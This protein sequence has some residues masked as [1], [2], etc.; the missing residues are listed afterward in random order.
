VR[1]PSPPSRSDLHPEELGAYD[2]MLQRQSD[3]GLDQQVPYF[4][5]LLNSPLTCHYINELGVV[6]R[7]HGTRGD[8]YA[9]KDRAWVDLVLGRQMEK[10]TFYAFILPAAAY[11]VR[12]A[13]IEAVW[14]ERDGNLTPEELELTVYIRQ[15]VSQTVTDASYAAIEERLG[16]R[17]AVELTAFIGHLLMTLTLMKAFDSIN[18][19]ATDEQ[20]EESIRT[21]LDGTADATEP[22]LPPIRPPIDH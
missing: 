21:V 4:S 9:Q 1:P 22:I 19:V 6:Y 20:I 5:A 16:A 10:G 2:R 14:R 3:Y 13:A 7:W 12:P 11:G 18:Y 15:V 8:S 17:G